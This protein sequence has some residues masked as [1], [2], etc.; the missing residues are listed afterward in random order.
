[1]TKLDANS[2]Y[3]QMKLD[4]DSQLLT[5][6]ITPLGRFCCIRGPFGLTSM[7]E[8]FNKCMNSIDGLPGVAKSTDDFLA[9]G[10]TVEEHDSCLNQ[11]LQRF[12]DKKV[13]LNKSK[14]VFKVKQVEFLGHH[15]SP[16]RVRPLN[17]RSQASRTSQCQPI[18][19]NS[20]DLWAWLSNFQNSPT[21]WQLLQNH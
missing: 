18:S 21:S 10:K 4:K 9:H 2:G 20:G 19:P 16:D 3:L 6:F 13:T 5:P 7:Q 12:K 17:P 8:I 14:C 15:I 1:M 11:I